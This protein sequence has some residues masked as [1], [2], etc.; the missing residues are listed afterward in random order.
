MLQELF[1]KRCPY[2]HF[3]TSYQFNTTY[4]YTELNTYW[5]C[6]N[7]CAH[8]NNL[9]NIVKYSHTI[10]LNV[11]NCFFNFRVNQNRPLTNFI[12]LLLCNMTRH[13]VD[14]IFKNCFTLP[15]FVWKKEVL[16]AIN[17]AKIGMTPYL[18]WTLRINLHQESMFSIAGTTQNRF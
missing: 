8:L 12:M 18:A 5:S 16:T 7:L 17:S 14:S 9:F 3:V 15:C 2:L 1:L 13:I 10:L 11:I 6:L 4:Y